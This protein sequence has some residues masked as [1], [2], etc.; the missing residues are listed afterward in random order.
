[1]LRLTFSSEWRCASA[2]PVSCPWPIM[3]CAP[4]QSNHWC[5]FFHSRILFSQLNLYKYSNIYS[6]LEYSSTALLDH[7]RSIISCDAHWLER[8]L[9]PLCYL[10][11]R[12]FNREVRHLQTPAANNPI[13]HYIVNVQADERLYGT[14]WPQVHC[15]GKVFQV[16]QR[17]FNL[18]V[19]LGIQFWH[20]C[21]FLSIW[22][23]QLVSWINR[24]DHGFKAKSLYHLKRDHVLT[25]VKNYGPCNFNPLWALPTVSSTFWKW[26]LDGGLDQFLF[27]C[28]AFF[29]LDLGVG[30]IA[31]QCWYSVT[32][33][34][35]RW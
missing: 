33:F 20:H 19:E 27:F 35:L 9:E 29:R 22:V 34:I 26:L 14:A 25:Q 12:M 31:W 5:V 6:N 32:C 30:C 2:T 17:L 23:T 18:F 15:S 11:G 1:M 4:S 3:Q 10:L 24:S 8:F 21:F 7:I 28:P 16:T 13:V